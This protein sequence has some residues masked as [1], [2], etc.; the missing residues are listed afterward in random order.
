MALKS[1][2][3][4]AELSVADIDR[5]Y[6]RDH[7]LTVARHQAARR[8]HVAAGGDADEQAF[9]ARQAQD[10]LVRFFR[11]HLDLLVGG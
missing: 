8:R 4:R 6:Y 5:G 10:H 11:T 7:T 1:T 2:I 3:F 9:L